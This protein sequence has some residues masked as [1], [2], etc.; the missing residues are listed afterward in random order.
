LGQTALMRPRAFFLQIIFPA[1]ELLIVLQRL[2][3]TV[4]RTMQFRGLRRN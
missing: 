1:Y 3:V 2:A 4:L